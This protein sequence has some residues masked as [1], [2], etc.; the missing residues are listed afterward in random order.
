MKYPG[1]RSNLHPQGIA[2]YPGATLPPTPSSIPR[3]KMPIPTGNSSLPPS[4]QSSII[5]PLISK[6]IGGTGRLA[7]GRQSLQIAKSK[8]VVAVP[9]LAEGPAKAA[10]PAGPQ[11]WHQSC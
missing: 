5:F 4:L 3:Q 10:L 8:A 6:S 7:S 11:A 9:A 2:T 1:Q